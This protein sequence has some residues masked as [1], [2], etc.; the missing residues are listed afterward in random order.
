[1]PD[2][3]LFDAVSATSF[4]PRRDVEAQRA[5]ELVVEQLQARNIRGDREVPL[6]ALAGPRGHDHEVRAQD[7]VT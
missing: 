5:A 7:E 1:M 2:V 3:V 4:G 6:D